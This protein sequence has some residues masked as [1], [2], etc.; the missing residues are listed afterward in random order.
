MM[1]LRA[2]GA[3]LVA[4]VGLTWGASASAIVV[5]GIDFGS[6]GTSHLDTTTL[7]ETL[8]NAQGQTL[9]GY[10]QVNTVNGESQNQYCAVDANCRL[11]F[12][13]SYNTQAFNGVSAA[14]NSGSVVVYYDPNGA[15]FNLLSQDSNAN[16]AYIESLD[17]W[18][19]L[20]GHAGASILCNALL[21][22]AT[23]EICATSNLGNVN[24]SFNGSGLLD[25]DVG[26]VGLAD[27]QNY[28]NGNSEVD[29]LGG[30]ADITFNT[31]GS[32]SVLNPFDTCNGQPGEWC[33]QGSAD[34]RGTTVVDVPEPGSLA[35]VGLALA[36]FGLVR[37]RRQPRA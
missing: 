2:L 22:V 6:P 24:T 15:N 10:G 9:L 37:A 7:A 33:L 18:V 12:T 11:F 25:V 21:G 19:G 31:S 4:S 27:V 26:G 29:G 3:A 20:T 17:P 14:F 8:V 35:L 34:L 36:G 32:N 28:L 1:K 30:F 5:G 13:I 23:T 16:L